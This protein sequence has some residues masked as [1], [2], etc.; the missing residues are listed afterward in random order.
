MNGPMRQTGF[1]LVILVF[2][3]VVPVRA[4]D[5]ALPT[6][7]DV[8]VGFKPLPAD[9]RTPTHKVGL[10]MPISVTLNGGATAVA[11]NKVTLV[12]M[13]DDSEDC[14]VLT[15]VPVA[16]NPGEKK[17]V[18]AYA[19]PG[20]T[21]GDI[22]VTL[23]LPGHDISLGPSLAPPT[24]SELGN[25]LYL[26]LGAKLDELAAALTL[27]EKQAA[28]EGKT[29]TKQTRF[30]VYEDDPARVPDRWLGYDGVDLVILNTGDAAFVAQLKRL[31]RLR[32][33]LAW[34]A[35]GGRL[36]IPMH[37]DREDLISQEFVASA[38]GPARWPTHAATNLVPIEAWSGLQ[39]KPFPR[40]GEPAVPVTRL[41]PKRF[42]ADGWEIL[43]QLEDPTA[44][45]KPL[46][47][48]ARNPYGFGS[49]TFIAFPLDSG[50]FAKWAGQA[51]FFRTLVDQ[52][53]PRFL[54]QEKTK[55]A[56]WGAEAGIGDWG[57]QLQ[58]GLDNFDVPTLSFGSVASF[59]L[60]YVLLVSAVDYFVLRRFIHRLEATWMTLPLIVIGVSLAAYFALDTAGDRSI[61]VNQIDLLDIDLLRT[62]TGPMERLP[63]TH[64]TTF[65]T[66]RSDAI[67]TFEVGVHENVPNPHRDG[68]DPAVVGWFG[69]PDDGPAGMGRA[70]GQSLSS[71][72][73]TFDDDFN[74]IR[75]LAFP[76][77]GTKSFAADSLQRRHVDPRRQEDNA[78]AVSQPNEQ[79]FGSLEAALVY[80]PRDSLFKVSGT[81]KNDLPFDLEDANLFVFDRVYPVAGGLKKGANRRIEIREI[82]N[83]MLPS[84][85]RD[86]TDP[87]RPV[88]PHGVYDP[89]IALKNILFHERLDPTL[90]VRN[91][92]LRRLDWSW[93]LRDDPRVLNVPLSVLGTREAILV[94]RA[95]F[96]QGD[97]RAL[98]TG[99]TSLSLGTT[100]HDTKT[101]PGT[102][103]RLARDVYVRAILPVRPQP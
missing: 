69:R 94:G 32:P 31:D 78:P 26:S 56:L 58:R 53:G 65:F 14:G 19:K 66:V 85:W 18:V 64:D 63:Q 7:V 16:L 36:V 10:W 45:D 20:R 72:T 55:D 29:Q 86:K 79:H 101:W 27:R 4:Q 95:K 98:S 39:N 44:G 48:I 28:E 5:A 17:T 77:R 41:N 46:P 57:A 22:R 61:R 60:L 92:L 30:A 102:N 42:D 1:A 33:L 8:Q 2:A 40:R 71:K 52:L 38:D 70:G 47:L 100:R 24:T 59:M 51:E 103:G 35:R 88:T 15:R 97:A 11:G 90:K 68:L 37:A 50:P 73:Y 87:H 67:R 49:I 91:H 12:V 93:R 84:D 83:G 13:A 82:D 80:H 3:C 74:R 43:A 21:R 25:Y 23:E 54:S 89:G 75:D 81:I 99:W 76:F 9:G 62:T 34:V 96:E 6:I